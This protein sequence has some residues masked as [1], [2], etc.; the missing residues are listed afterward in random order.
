MNK[1][2]EKQ[3]KDVDFS[4]Q[5][6]VVGLMSGTLYIFDVMAFN[7]MGRSDYSSMKVNAT[8]DTG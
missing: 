8:T 5:D 3:Y 7:E 1:P 6:K 4:T 2:E